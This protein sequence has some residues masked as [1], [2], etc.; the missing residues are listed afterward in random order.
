M[1]ASGDNILSFWGLLVA[2]ESYWGENRFCNKAS[3]KDDQLTFGQAIAVVEK[4]FWN[5]LSKTRRKRD[6]NNPSDLSSWHETYDRFL[7]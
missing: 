1:S 7:I 2:I 5:G 4:D 6:K 3:I